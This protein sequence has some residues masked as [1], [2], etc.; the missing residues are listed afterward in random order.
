M[1]TGEICQ[2]FNI[3]R[4]TL[5]HYIKHGLLNPAKDT[6]DYQWSDQDMQDLSNILQLRDLGLSI[7][8]IKQIKD[9]HDKYCG[10]LEQWVENKSILENEVKKRD[11]H[12]KKLE[13]E[14]EQLLSLIDKLNQN[15][16]STNT[17][18]P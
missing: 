17:K 3:T 1:K 13:A 2:Q 16:I 11:A 12:I 10:T 4:D 9:T 14:K 5:R 15:I 7:Q 18:T 8:T 6:K